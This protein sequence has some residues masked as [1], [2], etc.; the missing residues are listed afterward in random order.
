V[1]TFLYIGIVKAFGKQDLDGA[2]KAWEQ[3]VALAP[4]SREGQAAKRAI[5]SLGSAHPPGQT[6][7]TGG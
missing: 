3:A 1:R 7:P 2:M 6:P 4:D 5:D